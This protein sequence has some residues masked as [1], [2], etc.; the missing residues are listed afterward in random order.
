MEINS[1]EA[2]K[3]N[4]IPN[5][6]SYLA[7]PKKED[8]YIP[9]AL[10]DLLNK[11]ESQ[12]KRFRRGKANAQSPQT[13][14]TSSRQ[15]LSAAI[16]SKVA[17]MKLL[18]WSQRI[19]GL[20]PL[21]V[22]SETHQNIDSEFK[23]VELALNLT[24]AAEKLCNQE[25]D[26][27]KNLLSSCYRVSATAATPVQKVVHYFAEALR[28]KIDIER[29]HIDLER[30][31]VHVEEF[32]NHVQ[33][34]K[35]ACEVELP[36]SQITG[37]VA[38]QAILESVGSAARIHII[39]FRVRC[40]SHWPIM[41]HAIANR[42]NCPLELL[43]ITAVGTSK[44][45]LE[46]TGRWL[47]SFAESMNLPFSFRIVSSAL[48]DLKI[49]LFELEA[50]E[51]VAL[52]LDVRLW[53]LLARPTCLEAFIGV[54]NNLNP[55]L[56]VVAE[57]EVNTNTSLFL[58]RF[59]EAL[60]FC[61]AIFDCFETCLQSVSQFRKRTE[62]VCIQNAIREV[63]TSEDEERIHRHERIEFWRELFS[64]FGIVEM[65]LSHS[66]LFQ[67][68]LVLKSCSCW[69]SCTI[70]MNGKSMILQ[71]KETPIKSISA[72]KFPRD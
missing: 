51:V 29:G 62:E 59:Y 44:D 16:I 13:R 56:M 57:M 65:E 55:C 4:K 71:W 45:M 47:L 1:A 34:D 28:D 26:H 69:S 35:I 20:L 53:S 36:F 50:H 11:C 38:T 30:K 68:S 15:V 8:S 22:P 10:F 58:H 21:K 5:K 24:L 18:K 33:P 17:K 60:F 46:D 49:D 25:F 12:L 52:Y 41:M 63:I 42:E 3:R 67:A 19:D 27:A 40:G 9:V 61:S 14:G 64:R 31:T 37:F 43:K 23:D 32:P 6:I 54:I 70:N 39:D 72:W 2:S 48:E 7:E 66:S